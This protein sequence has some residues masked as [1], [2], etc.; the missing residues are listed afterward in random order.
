LLANSRRIELCEVGV[1]TPLL[2]PAISSKAVGPIQNSTEDKPIPASKIHTELVNSIEEAVLI[3]A[4]DIHFGYVSAP[5]SFQHGFSDSQ[6]AT[7]KV[8]FIDSGWYEKSVGPASGQW[9]YE[10]G[11]A[12]EF[13]ESDYVALVDSLDPVLRAVLVSWDTASDSSDYLSQIEAAQEFFGSRNRFNSTILLKPE[14]SRLF[15]DFKDL[16]TG[17]ADRL[18]AFDTVGVTEK[19]LGDSI[20]RRLT[21]LAQL[22]TRLMKPLFPFPFMCSGDSTL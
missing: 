3:S 11:P 18:R 8:L 20:L 6:Y 19:E 16:S 21:Q 4:Y 7:P 10:A 2:V 22:R 15:H 13:T 14:R 5:E 12:Q 17:A 1:Q 9:Y